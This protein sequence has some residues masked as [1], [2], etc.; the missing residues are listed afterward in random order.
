MLWY[1]ILGFFSCF[2]SLLILAY[3]GEGNKLFQFKQKFG[4]IT[5]FEFNVDSVTFKES[6]ISGDDL[7]D[8]LIASLSNSSHLWENISVSAGKYKVRC[9]LYC[10]FIEITE[11]LIE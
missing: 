1:F 2:F 7:T 6:E 8:F 5:N 11:E 4:K 3:F 9:K 10:D